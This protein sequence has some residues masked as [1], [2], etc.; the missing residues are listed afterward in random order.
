MSFIL[1]EVFIFEQDGSMPGFEKTTDGTQ[2]SCFSSAIGPD[3]GHDL[4]LFYFEG[5]PFKGLDLAVISV[6]AI[7]DQDR[8]YEIFS[9]SNTS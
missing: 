2:G 4:S 3:Q 9:L 5:D 1:R 8:H 6:Y 7:N